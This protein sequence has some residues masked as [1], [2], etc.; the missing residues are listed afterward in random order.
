ML[1]SS[2]KRKLQINQTQLAGELLTLK[3]KV[4]YLGVT[5]DQ[6]L[7]MSDHVNSVTRFC[8]NEL[9]ILYKIEHYLTFETR[10]IAVQNL[11]KSRLDYCNSLLSGISKMDI[12]KLQRVRN[13]A[14]RFIFSV[15]R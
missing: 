5:L 11:I 14:C 15:N 2:R 9:R 10:K 12:M 1:I 7:S 6:H 13:A 4:V 3:P 8:Y